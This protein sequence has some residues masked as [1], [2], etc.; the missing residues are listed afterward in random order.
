[1][2]PLQFVP[3]KRKDNM[4]PHF[5]IHLYMSKTE[6]RAKERKDPISHAMKVK[7]VKCET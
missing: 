5:L 6:R 2:M 7:V 3:K 1:M 4:M